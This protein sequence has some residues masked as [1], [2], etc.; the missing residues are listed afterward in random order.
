MLFQAYYYNYSIYRTMQ[1]TYITE[2]YATI[3]MALTRI[4]IPIV[5]TI[6]KY[7]RS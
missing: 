3:C 1:T 5:T 6:T 2:S 4:I 7:F